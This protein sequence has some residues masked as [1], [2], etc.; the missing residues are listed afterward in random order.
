[1]NRTSIAALSASSF[2]PDVRHG[3]TT[4]RTC[5]TLPIADFS[6]LDPRLAQRA[7][8]R[9]DQARLQGKEQRTAQRVRPTIGSPLPQYLG[10]TRD[11]HRAIQISGSRDHGSCHSD[12][13]NMSL[14]PKV[15]CPFSRCGFG[16]SMICDLPD[17]NLARLGS[18]GA[19]FA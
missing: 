2:L 8:T 17:L 7:L 11:G 4:G 10:R 19:R 15:L 14:C 6:R 12:P 3:A 13:E 18:A 16:P 1:M 9:P 5:Q